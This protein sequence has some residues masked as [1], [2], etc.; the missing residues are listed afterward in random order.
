MAQSARLRAA[1]ERAGCFADGGFSVPANPAI[2]EEDA[3]II[4][5]AWRFL[6]ERNSPF[7]RHAREDGSAS[8]Q[9]F[10]RGVWT[11]NTFA[12]DIAESVPKPF[13]QNLPDLPGMLGID[14]ASHGSRKT[15]YFYFGR[16][17]GAL[18]I[19]GYAKLESVSPLF[20]V[21]D[22]RYFVALSESDPTNRID[23]PAHVTKLLG[24]SGAADEVGGGFHQISM[25]AEDAVWELA[26]DLAFLV[27]SL[28][29]DIPPTNQNPGH[30]LNCYLLRK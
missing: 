22:G 11:R 1:L 5:G 3:K 27:T 7:L 30:F 18:D 28:Y 21:E 19:S 13:G 29:L 17:S 25:R 10:R 12:R 16:D 6:T 15:A 14:S 9:R 4:V 26:P 2:A 24:N 8:P 20:C 23:V